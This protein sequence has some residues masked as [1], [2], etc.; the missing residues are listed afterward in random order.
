[1]RF[2]GSLSWVR[3]TLATIALPVLILGAL[4]WYA[5]STGQSIHL[6]SGPPG[7]PPKPPKPP[8]PTHAAPDRSARP[9]KP[10]A[11]AP[12]DGTPT[13]PDQGP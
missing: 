3:K 1:M 13:D 2:Q 11:T 6:T 12:A 4:T 8:K 5:F 7:K 9:A 10:S